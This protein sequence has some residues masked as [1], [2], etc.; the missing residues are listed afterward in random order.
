MQ[1][2]PIYFLDFST[3]AKAV[4]LSAMSASLR[5][6]CE[7]TTTAA[8]LQR[9]LYPEE[10]GSIKASIKSIRHSFLLWGLGMKE[11][12][13]VNGKKIKKGRPLGNF[14]LLLVK[15]TRVY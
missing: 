15:F 7:N 11:R 8:A 4:A 2:F 5:R 13:L 3:T 6:Y 12:T 9:A 10:F 1:V 14:T